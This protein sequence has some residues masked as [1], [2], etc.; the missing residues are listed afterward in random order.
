MRIEWVHP[1]WRDL[2]IEH[3]AEDSTAG[4]GFSR[5]AASTA[6]HSRSR[7]PVDATETGSCRC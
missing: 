2:V 3:L 1:S 7:S 6:P 5:A 4:G